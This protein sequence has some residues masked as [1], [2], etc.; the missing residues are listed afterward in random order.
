MNVIERMNQLMEERGWSVYKLAQQ[1][2]LSV[3]TLAHIY[4]RHTTPSLSTLE[5]ICKAFGIT[6][7]QFFSE[8]DTLFPLTVE[9]KQLFDTWANLTPAQKELIRAL[10]REFK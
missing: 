8:G 1:S 7:S 6:L 10:I 2:G 5:A 4:R 9:Q 3:S